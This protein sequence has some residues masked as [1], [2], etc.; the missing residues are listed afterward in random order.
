MVDVR[1]ADAVRYI[2]TPD[3]IG[4]VDLWNARVTVTA[5]TPSFERE[6]DRMMF[7]RQD[8]RSDARED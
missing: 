2:L 6:G 7:E 3:D 5:G 8:G 4:V 1:N